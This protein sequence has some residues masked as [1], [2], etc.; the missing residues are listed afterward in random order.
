MEA[1]GASANYLT[2]KERV[3]AIVMDSVTVFW[4]VHQK[5][6][7]ADKGGRRRKLE[8][9]NSYDAVI[10]FLVSEEFDVAKLTKML[11]H[12]FGTNKRQLKRGR[13]LKKNL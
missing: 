1:A 5:R 9:Q 4:D 10:L 6:V 7:D 3:S 13:A 2:E 12:K 11:F 8:D